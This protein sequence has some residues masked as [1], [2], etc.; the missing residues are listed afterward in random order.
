[1]QWAWSSQLLL[2]ENSYLLATDSEKATINKVMQTDLFCRQS[3]HFDDCG[4]IS[5]DKISLYVFCFAV[6]I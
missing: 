2:Q 5:R 1:M 3:F 4:V 6:V